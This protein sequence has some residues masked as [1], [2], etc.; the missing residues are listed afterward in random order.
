[1]LAE[2]ITPSCC[3]VL[4]LLTSSHAWTPSTCVD[5][6]H[7][8]PQLPLE[9]PLHRGGL[10]AVVTRPPGQGEEWLK[11]EGGND[12]YLDFGAVSVFIFRVLRQHLA[13]SKSIG[14]L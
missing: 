1:L 2:P 7:A 3:Y 8:L 9:G 10:A 4:P 12:I 6:V 13:V 5:E 14:S 11:A